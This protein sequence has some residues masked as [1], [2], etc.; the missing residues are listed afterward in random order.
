M[1]PVY[2][3]RNNNNN[4][5]INIEHRFDLAFNYIT[6][7]IGSALLNRFVSY[8]FDNSDSEEDIQDE[9]LS[10]A[11]RGE[12]NKSARQKNIEDIIERG[13]YSGYKIL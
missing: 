11:E 8:I 4:H 10:M 5:D 3:D 12:Y 1:F 9:S 6:T 2:F 7:A 13:E